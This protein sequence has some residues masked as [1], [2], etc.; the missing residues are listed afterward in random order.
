MLY[1]ALYGDTVFMQI[2]NRYEIDLRQYRW[3][4]KTKGKKRKEKFK[5]SRAAFKYDTSRI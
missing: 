4:K 2:S 3:G 1:R 5:D